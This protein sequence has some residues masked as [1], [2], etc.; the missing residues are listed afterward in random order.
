LGIILTA[1]GVFKI[2]KDEDYL[3]V[4]IDFAG[5]KLRLSDFSPITSSMI[6]GSTFY[7]SI[8]DLIQGKGFDN[9]FNQL[10]VAV[11]NDTPLDFISDAIEYSDTSSE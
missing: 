8:K 9:A 2:D 1:L 4:V 10:L 7:E 11:L 5:I 6:V 3:G